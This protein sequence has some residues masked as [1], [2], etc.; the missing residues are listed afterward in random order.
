[1]KVFITIALL[2][3]WSIAG[4]QELM[5]KHR[6]KSDPMLEEKPYNYWESRHVFIQE[7][8]EGIVGMLIRNPSHVFTAE[9]ST[10]IGFYS[11]KGELLLMTDGW[12]GI[13]ETGGLTMYLTH[14]YT[15][16]TASVYCRKPNPKNEY[17]EY[18]LREIT[19]KNIVDK[20]H[21]LKFLKET[22][23]YIRIITP[24]Y[25]GGHFDVKAKLKKD[26]SVG[27]R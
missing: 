1:M 24:I 18:K 27:K 23:G 7:S 21:V 26:R 8:D 13:M 17:G 11:S 12:R 2:L 6:S 22:N 10:K 3:T 25:Y 4:A 14:G 5:I 15:A 9:N 16:D 19:K 20:E